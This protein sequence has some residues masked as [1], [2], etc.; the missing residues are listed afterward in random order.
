MLMKLTPDI[1]KSKSCLRNSTLLKTI[2]RSLPFE[3]FFCFAGSS[4]F[5]SPMIN[6]LIQPGSTFHTIV[7]S[8]DVET[9]SAML[10]PS[11]G[12]MMS[13]NKLYFFESSQDLRGKSVNELF[14]TGRAHYKIITKWLIPIEY[15][16]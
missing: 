5:L 7:P 6:S 11:S 2:P 15:A 4:P 3:S 12:R 14:K 16:G 13:R 1:S 8:F 9:E 10:D